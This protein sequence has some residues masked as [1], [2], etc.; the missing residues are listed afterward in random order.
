MKPVF[1]PTVQSYLLHC[2]LTDGVSVGFFWVLS[3]APLICVSG[4]RPY[5]TCLDYSFLAV[6]N[7]G[8]WHLLWFF[9]KIQAIFFE[10]QFW[11][12]FVLVPWK[13]PLVSW[14]GFRLLLLNLKL[15]PQP[16]DPTGPVISEEVLLKGAWGTASSARPF[17][18]LI[19]LFSHGYDLYSD[20]THDSHHQDMSSLKVKN[21][22]LNS[23]PKSPFLLNIN[24][25]T[26]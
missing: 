23:S 10:I 25:S 21:H 13:M 24:F 2:G 5:H 1:S 11:E 22:F 12:F 15:V 19:K 9:L 6:W 3:P 17:P 26:H 20:F 7:Q 16:R 8:A 14:P 18:I 4:Y